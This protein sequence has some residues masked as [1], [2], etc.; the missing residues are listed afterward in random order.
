MKEWFDY[1]FFADSTDMWEIF[2]ICL[3]IS[4]GTN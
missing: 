1:F 2:Y 3:K 4:H